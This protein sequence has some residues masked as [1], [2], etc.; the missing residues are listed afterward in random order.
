MCKMYPSFKKH[1][2]KRYRLLSFVEKRLKET[3]VRDTVLTHNEIQQEQE[4]QD[5]TSPY[6]ESFVGEINFKSYLVCK[7]KDSEGPIVRY[8]ML[9]GFT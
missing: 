2:N 3:K 9:S 5:T 8:K 4:T 6:N 7:E 1:Q